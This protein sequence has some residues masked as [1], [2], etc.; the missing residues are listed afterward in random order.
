MAA[1]AVAVAVVAAL[2]LLLRS[3]VDPRGLMN[4][5]RWC[6]F[7]CAPLTLAGV[8]L[9]VWSSWGGA[10][11]VG[12]LSLVLAIPTLVGLAGSLLPERQF[13]GVTAW[14]LVV[15]LLAFTVLSGL[16]VG[17]YFLPA[18]L[19]LLGAAAL[20]PLSTTGTATPAAGRPVP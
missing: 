2:A 11:S 13:H 4:L 12:R 9:A 20:R 16:T 19:A 10:N 6:R 14:G 1:V 17:Y 3:R 5:A 7:A 15:L 8:A 18:L